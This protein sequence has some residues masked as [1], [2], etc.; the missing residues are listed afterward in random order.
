[1]KLIDLSLF[2]VYNE[3]FY[4]HTFFGKIE[5]R[6]HIIFGFLA[7]LP[8]HEVKRQSQIFQIISNQKIVFTSNFSQNIYNLLPLTRVAKT[9]QKL[10]ASS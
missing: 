8:T 2:Q 1:M 9:C 7:I 10:F 4:V 5:R 3:K 6:I